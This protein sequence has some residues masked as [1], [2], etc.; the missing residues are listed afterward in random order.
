[1]I[2]PASAVLEA[3]E[4]AQAARLPPVDCYRAGVEAWRRAHPAH[5]RTRLKGR[6]VAAYRDTGRGACSGLS[7]PA[8]TPYPAPKP[9]GEPSF[10]L[11]K[12][13][14]RR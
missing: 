7:A 1:M 10:V 14:R 5:G 8:V 3:F 13:K 2:R 6:P 12:R 11:A 9:I 4:A